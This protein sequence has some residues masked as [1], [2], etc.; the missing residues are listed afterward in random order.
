M[1]SRA[2]LPSP[3]WWRVK[4]EPQIAFARAD[5]WKN[6]RDRTLLWRL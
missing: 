5:C 3:R 1:T 2:A 4:T 6:L